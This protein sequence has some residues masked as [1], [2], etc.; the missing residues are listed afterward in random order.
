MLVALK[1][2]A[3]SSLSSCKLRSELD[4]DVAFS[5]AP[6]GIKIDIVCF[7]I[8]FVLIHE[9]FQMVRFDVFA[10]EAVELFCEQRVGTFI[11][12]ALFHE[13]NEMNNDL[14]QKNYGIFNAVTDQIP[15]AGGI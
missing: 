2:T 14:R 4:F 8:V 11:G 7:Q 5:A 9:P 1:I 12:T 3:T 15:C 6:V 13:F 10:A